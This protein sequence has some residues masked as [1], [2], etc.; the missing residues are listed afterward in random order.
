[1]IALHRLGIRLCERSASTPSAILASFHTASFGTTSY[2]L[3]TEKAQPPLQDS[4]LRKCAV[5]LSQSNP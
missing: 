2:L 4:D 5:P 3:P 1:M